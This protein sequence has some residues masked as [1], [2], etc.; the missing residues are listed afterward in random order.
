MKYIIPAI[1]IILLM[2]ALGAAAD[3]EWLAA[4]V[5]VGIAIGLYKFDKSRSIPKE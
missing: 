2:V 5:S 4:I 1:V 3:R